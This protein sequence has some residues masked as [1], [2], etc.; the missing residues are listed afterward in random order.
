[1]TNRPIKISAT[2]ALSG[3]LLLAGAGEAGAVMRALTAAATGLE[4]QQANIERISNDIANVNT[5]GYKRGRV[6]LEDLMYETLKQPG[7]SL[8]AAT[9]SPVG[10]QR[11]MGV[12]VNGAYKIFEQ[13]PAR[14]TGHPYDLMI[15]GRGFFPVQTPQGDVAYTR[16]GAF[17]LDNQGRLVLT[18]GS[19]L[20]P[21]ITIPQNASRVI[22]TQSGE[23]VALLPGN[24]QA[25][26]GQIQLVTF[27]NRQGLVAEGGGLYKVS[28][29]SGEPV[30]GI[31][32]ENGLGLID[33][34]ALEGSN[35]NIAN[36][37]TEMITTQRAYEMQTKIM[38]TANEMLGATV[39]LK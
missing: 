20:L 16:T 2:V 24:E 1:M 23:V 34:G 11:G 25:I 18:G 9:Q 30:Q 31:P 6:E 28:A 12:K 5:D 10:I 8:G 14:M 32:G 38:S 26:L 19:L 33:Q 13:G 36:S 15:E 29:A 4:A 21:Q 27:Q 17:H 7:G 39:N 37:M 35:V 22:I 3:I